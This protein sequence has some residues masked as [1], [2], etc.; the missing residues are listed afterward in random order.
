MGIR[1]LLI[2]REGETR[3]KY[4]EA[5][6][7]LGVEV[8]VASSLKKTDRTLM[9]LSYHGV[10][11]D[12]RTKIEILKDENELVYTTLRKFPVAHLNLERKTGEIRL[13]LFR[14]KGRSHTGEL[15]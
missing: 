4:Q 11:V 1:I 15:Y 5:I 14:A 7:D 3:G 8:V 10:M 12:M 9:D 13:F 6:T 2:A